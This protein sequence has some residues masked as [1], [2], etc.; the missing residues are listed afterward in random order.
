[1][2]TISIHPYPIICKDKH[3]YLVFYNVAD[4]SLLYRDSVRFAFGPLIQKEL[5]N[6]V[7]EW[8]HHHIRSSSMAE[9]PSGIPDVLFNFPGLHG[10]IVLETR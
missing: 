7:V 2:K 8:N 1:M 3:Y 6:F 4:Y 10:V 5:D 9:T